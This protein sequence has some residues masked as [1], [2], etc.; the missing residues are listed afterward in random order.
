MDGQN[1]ERS[2]AMALWQDLCDEIQR[3][4]HSVNSVGRHRMVVERTPL[5]LS[6]TDLNTRKLLRLSYHENGPSI[7]YRETG[8]SDANITFREEQIS[9]SLLTL[10]HCGMPQSPQTL[11]VS[12][13]IGLTRF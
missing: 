7:K 2:L 13:M 9:P 11:A 5:D 12:L 6:I 3:E 4:C 10:M 8:K 1:S